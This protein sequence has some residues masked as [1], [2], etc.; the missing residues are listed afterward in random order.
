LSSVRRT[1]AKYAPHILWGCIFLGI[2]LAITVHIL[3]GIVI[4]IIGFVISRIEEKKA[5]KA[6]NKKRGEV[7]A[8]HSVEIE[9]LREQG[10]SLSLKFKNEKKVLRGIYEKKMNDK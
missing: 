2:I 6:Y 8:K 9:A 10:R 1:G 5:D 3:L 4:G 7:M